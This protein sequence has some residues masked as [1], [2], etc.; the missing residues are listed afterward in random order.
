MT[1]PSEQARAW[2]RPYFWA[3]VLAI[4]G[5]VPAAYAVACFL[6][7]LGAERPA[8]PGTTTF[9]WERRGLTWKRWEQ[10]IAF[11]SD[12]RALDPFYDS[13]RNW[14]VLRSG[15]WFAF[16]RGGVIT[17]Y[18]YHQI[19]DDG[20][21]ML[22]MCCFVAAIVLAASG[23]AR[24]TAFFAGHCAQCGYDLRESPDRCPECGTPK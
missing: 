15:R 16:G 18:T 7:P 11:P 2:R 24:R 12:D 9:S 21:G 4:I 20:Y 6:R 5:L 1:I 3:I 8:P 23:H 19:P 13:R 10:P 14:F 17:P 22:G